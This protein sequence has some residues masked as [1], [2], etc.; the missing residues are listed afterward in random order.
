MAF[1]RSLSGPGL[2]VQAWTRPS[3]SR[4]SS[5]PLYQ[6]GLDSQDPPH[7]EGVRVS[8]A[9]PSRPPAASC[10]ATGPQ[11]PASTRRTSPVGT[12]EGVGSAG[13]ETPACRAPTAGLTW[14]GRAQGLGLS[15]GLGL[16]CSGLPLWAAG[17]HG[18][19]L[20]RSFHVSKGT[21]RHSPKGIVR[22]CG[23]TAPGLQTPPGRGPWAL[24]PHRARGR[25]RRPQDLCTSHPCITPLPATV[26]MPGVTLA[27]HLHLPSSATSQPTDPSGQEGGPGPSWGLPSALFQ[28][29]G[30]ATVPLPVQGAPGGCMDHSPRLPLAN[31]LRGFTKPQCV[32]TAP[33]T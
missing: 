29:L 3:P 1:S 6:K 27:S 7:A 19:S 5:A 16:R 20:F 25:E 13:H 30:A 15:R 28:A 32:C 24:P 17:V 21:C 26:S 9:R 23:A 11:T 31:P 14:T 22:L 12:W 33:K 2:P 4:P 18:L 10:P 8:R